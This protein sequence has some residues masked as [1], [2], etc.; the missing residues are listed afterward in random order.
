MKNKITLLGGFALCAMVVV[1]I[2]S[3]G[4]EVLK[5]T[6]AV[7]GKS[8]TEDFDTMAN[9][10]KKGWAFNNRSTP[11]GAATWQQGV[12]AIGKFGPDGFAAYSYE[13]SPDEYAFAGYASGN[14]LS[15]LDSW[16]ITPPLQMKNGDKISFYTRTFAGSTFPDR[17][18]VRINLVDASTD[19]GNT[20]T[21]IGKF[22]TLITDINPTLA[23]GGYPEDWT[24]VSYTISGLTAP[25]TGRVAFRYFVAAGGPSGANSNAIGIDLFKFE[26]L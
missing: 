24:K 18:Q 17:M 22:T 25:V 4:K 6:P 2:N 14:N 10:Y 1:L 19:L 26:S 8:L 16:M 9:L 3:C 11:Q 7:A 13:Q 12:Y 21:S 23:L 5:T 15:D 20:S